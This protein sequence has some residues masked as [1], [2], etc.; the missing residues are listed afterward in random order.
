VRWFDRFADRC[1][2]AVASAPFF[3]GCCL[4]VA[5]WLPSLPL[6]PSLETW[7]LPINTVTTIVT[8]LLVA[9]VHNTQ[10]RFERAVT[11]RLVEMERHLGV[12]DPVDDDGQQP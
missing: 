8:F 11:E 6:F 12:P 2:D 4:L 7:Q 5:L 3:M 9:L 1:G 10:R